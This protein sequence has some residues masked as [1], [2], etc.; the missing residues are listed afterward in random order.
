MRCTGKAYLSLSVMLIVAWMIITALEW[1]LRTA[2]FLFVIGIPVFFIALLESCLN[3]FGKEENDIKRKELKHIHK[4]MAKEKTL[5]I[6]LWI[7]GFFLLIIFFGFP[8]AIL[9]F[10]FLYL[11]FKGS[12]GWKISLGLAVGG[13]GLFYVLF[14]LFLHVHFMDGLVQRAIRTLGIG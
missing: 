9:L 4:V 3:L 6:F 5:S 12:E 1:P 14:V 11:K 10:I 7:I 13:W 2:T 8:L